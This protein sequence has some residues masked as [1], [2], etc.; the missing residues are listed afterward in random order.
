MMG[1]ID[2]IGSSS[3]NSWNASLRHSW[4]TNRVHPWVSMKWLLPASNFCGGN[5]STV[6]F[7]VHCNFQKPPENEP[8][9]S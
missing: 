8:L 1:I 6:S 4:G 2:N 5:F 3:D 7:R 9:V